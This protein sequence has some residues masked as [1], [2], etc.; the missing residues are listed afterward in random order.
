MPAA[1]RKEPVLAAILNL[2]FGIG[3][4]Y[5]GFRKVLSITT[6]LFVILVLIVDI[7]I[8]IFTFGLVPLV[9]A[10]L[11]AYDGYLKAKGEKGYVGTEPALLYQP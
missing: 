6:I 4:L 2:F 5:L 8:G 9:I 11:L 1:Q 10:I 7:I 3:Y